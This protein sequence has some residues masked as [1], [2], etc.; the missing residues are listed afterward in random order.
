MKKRRSKHY[1]EIFPAA[2]L[3]R[4]KAWQTV[5]E[6]LPEGS[7]LLVL[8]KN[9]NATNQVILDLARALQEQGRKVICILPSD[10]NSGKLRD[11]IQDVN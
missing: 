9:E 7:W 4:R 3:P 5:G 2:L 1:I 10:A 6:S 8:P 11:Q